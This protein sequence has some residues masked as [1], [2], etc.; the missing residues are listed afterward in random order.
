[1]LR[2]LLLLLMPLCEEDDR[3]LKVLRNL[4]SRLEQSVYVHIKRLTFQVY[5]ISNLCV[6]W[7]SIVQI[8]KILIFFLQLP[9]MYDSTDGEFRG[10]SEKIM[11]IDWR[12][13]AGEKMPSVRERD[14]MKCQKNLR[15]SSCKTSEP[16]SK[17]EAIKSANFKRRKKKVE[18]IILT[19]AMKT[20]SEHAYK[21]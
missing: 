6:I 18:K 11:F 21:F 3:E 7:L 9:L 16:V 20:A 13:T 10:I 17:Y 2:I 14:K 12:V 4:L 19:L 5:Q 15:R 8:S 1:M